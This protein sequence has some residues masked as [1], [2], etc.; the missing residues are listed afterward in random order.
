[1][2][3]RMARHPRS[4]TR[5]LASIEFAIVLPILLSLLMVIAEVGR[6]LAQY[7]TLTKS[8]RNG[9]R[10]LA[11][12]ALLGTTGVVSITP[13]V[14]TAT[15]NLVAT[16]NVSGAGAKLLPGLVVAN[17][18]VANAGGGYVSVS[19]SYPYQPLLGAVLPNFGTGPRTSFSFP[20]NSTVIMRAL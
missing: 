13:A 9:A 18:T 3:S 19:A 4:C 10:Y 5:G 2:R 8:V 15:A 11:A 16:G 14:Q 20:L 1:M 12:N 6:L 17:I 7:D